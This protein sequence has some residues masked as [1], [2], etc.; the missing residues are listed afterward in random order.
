MRIHQVGPHEHDLHEALGAL[1]VAAYLP[2]HPE[3]VENGYGEELADVAG[4]IANAVVLAALSDEGDELLGGVTYVPDRSSPLASFDADRAAGIRMLA[5]DPQSQ[6]SGVGEALVR[7]CIA[8]A[9]AEGRA[10]ILLHTTPSHDDRAPALR[11][12]RLPPRRVPRLVA[13]AR[14]PPPRLPPH[15]RAMLPVAGCSPRCTS[16]ATRALG[17]LVG[18]EERL[19]AQLLRGDIDWGADRRDD[20]EPSQRRVGDV[21][22]DVDDRYER[23]D[24]SWHGCECRRV[25]PR[26][27]LLHELGGVVVEYTADG[28]ATGAF[29]QC[30]A[31]RCPSSRPPSAP[32]RVR[33]SV[34]G[35]SAFQGSDVGRAAGRRGV[36]RR[37]W[38]AARPIGGSGRRLGSGSCAVRM[39][40]D[41]GGDSL[42]RG[43][44]EVVVGVQ[45]REAG[46]EQEAVAV[47]QRHLQAVASRS[48]IPRL[49]R[50]AP[51]LEEAHVPRGRHRR[52]RQIELAQPT[53]AAPVADE[54]T[55]RR[56]VGRCSRSTWR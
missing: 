2:L 27:E 6:R 54:I 12:A 32:V 3:F 33:A 9:E 25:R 44:V 42:D 36:L 5:V 16:S 18:R 29:E 19:D 43:V 24:D 40:S 38:C 48:T 56:A 17:V 13:R 11:A 20:R 55:E 49:A 22:M 15:A 28:F 50:G 30:R 14:L 51:G 35:R 45:R 26:A 39:R 46:G 21:E 31:R 8:R 47:A 10:E 34:E 52:R 23:S 53:D 37:R 7:A 1:T 4:R 41:G